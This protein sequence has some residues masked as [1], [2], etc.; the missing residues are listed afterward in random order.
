MDFAF[1]CN[2]E[3]RV[4]E[5]NCPVIDSPV[6]GGH[7]GEKFSSVTQFVDKLSPFL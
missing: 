7:D 6:H 2:E 4:K 3:G 1:V 5:K